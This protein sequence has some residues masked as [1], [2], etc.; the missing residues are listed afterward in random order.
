MVFTVNSLLGEGPTKSTRFLMT[1][2]KKSLIGPGTIEA[3][4]KLLGWSFNV[5]LTGV[6]PALDEN[7]DPLPSGGAPQYL[8][9]GYRA[10]LVKVHG[11]WEFYNSA[12][13][14]PT[15]RAWAGC[16]GYV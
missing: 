6:E 10:V 14:V 2:I 4:A 12:F 5:L 7:G 1:A 16:V 9:G 11:D 15:G 13:G 3:I 8:A